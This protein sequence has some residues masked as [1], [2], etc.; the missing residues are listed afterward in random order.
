M[1]NKNDKTL[2][3]FC[4]LVK[5]IFKPRLKK[6]IRFGKADLLLLFS[7]LA[8]E[9]HDAVAN[10]AEEWSRTHDISISPLALDEAGYN[11]L[12][13]EGKQLAKDIEKS[14]VVL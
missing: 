5:Q 9:D 12:V 10:L 4:D 1:K 7:Q 14:G 3:A 2:L 13:Q 6:V 8:P 11:K